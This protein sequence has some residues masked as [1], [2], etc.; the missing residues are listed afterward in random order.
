MQKMHSPRNFNG[1]LLKC[2]SKISYQN[3][4][5]AKSLMQ[6]KE[7]SIMARRNNHSHSVALKMNSLLNKETTTL[8]PGVLIRMWYTE[9]SLVR[10]HMDAWYEDTWISMPTSPRMCT[11]RRLSAKTPQ[12]PMNAPN[13]SRQKYPPTTPA[14]A[15]VSWT[16]VKFSLRSSSILCSIRKV[17]AQI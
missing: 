14:R 12:P 9:M 17:L 4:S 3:V 10:R 6:S 15:R 2:G 1:D 8:D 11:T 7:K 13:Y 5:L 16:C